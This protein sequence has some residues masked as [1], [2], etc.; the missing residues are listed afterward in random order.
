MKTWPPNQLYRSLG[1]SQRLK[2]QSGS[3]KWSMLGPLNVHYGCVACSCGTPNSDSFVCSWN[4][5]AP[6]GLPCQLR[7]EGLCILLHC[8]LLTTLEFLLFSEGNGGGMI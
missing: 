4:T 3:L 5:F 2:P 8:V 6:T 1:D 7:Y